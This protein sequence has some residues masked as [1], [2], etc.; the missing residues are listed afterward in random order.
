MVLWAAIACIRVEPKLHAH[1][2]EL[3]A[4]GR[5]DLR[6]ALQKHGHRKVAAKVGVKVNRRGRPSAQTEKLIVDRK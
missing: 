3:M 6:Y 1:C 5:A 2:R 4:A